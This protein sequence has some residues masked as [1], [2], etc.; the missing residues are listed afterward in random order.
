MDMDTAITVFDIGPTDFGASQ[1]HDL[2]QNGYF[3][4]NGAFA[5]S[6]CAAMAAAFDLIKQ[7]EGAR[8]GHEVSQEPGAVRVSNIFNKTDAFDCTLNCKPLLAAARYLLGDFK[9][10][11]ANVREPERGAGQQILHSDVT[12]LPDGSWRVINALILLDDMTLKNGPTRVVPGSHNWPAI[13]VP[14]E[15]LIEE[16]TAALMSGPDKTQEWAVEDKKT[17]DQKV[18]VSGA[19]RDEITPENPFAPYPG[20]EF[21]TAPAG[22]VIVTNAHLWHSGTR[23]RSGARRRMLHLSYTPRG[24]PQQFDQ[25]T[26]LTPALYERM[27]AARRYLL[28]I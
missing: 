10:H 21:L 8:A 27:S 17:S 2:D 20:E 26:N 1:R 15:N 11:G 4:V 5:L 19:G 25:R 12:R 22:T 14:D 9:V 16:A 3:C 24:Q 6:Q 23:N 28:D 18:V 13:N 7:Q